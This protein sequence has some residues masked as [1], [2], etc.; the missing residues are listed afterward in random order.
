MEKILQ[1]YGEQ[2]LLM[3]SIFVVV[4]G[5]F[6]VVPGMYGAGLGIMGLAFISGVLFEKMQNGEEIL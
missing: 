6:Q 3:G 1:E 4:F 5:L 2:V